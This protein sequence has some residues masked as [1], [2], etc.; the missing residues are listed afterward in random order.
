[1]KKIKTKKLNFDKKTV[2]ELNSK[3]M[4]KV[5]GGG[6]TIIIVNNQDVTGPKETFSV[7]CVR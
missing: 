3:Q 2:V 4:L 5:I 7:L 6:T 1:M